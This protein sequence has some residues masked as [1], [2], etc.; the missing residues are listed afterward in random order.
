MCVFMGERENNIFIY[1]ERLPYTV[2]AVVIPGRSGY[3]V[4]V[5]DH[6]S[7]EAREQAIIHELKH[8]R[9]GDPHSD[10]LA[11]DIEKDMKK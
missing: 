3:T 8:I 7:V 1:E 9:R 11:T 4:Y 6:L 10:K 2:R 5:N